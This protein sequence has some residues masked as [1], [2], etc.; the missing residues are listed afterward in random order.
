MD[1]LLALITL[2]ALAYFVAWEDYIKPWLVLD[3]PRRVK[4]LPPLPVYRARSARSARSNA[5][6]AG[7][8]QQG[9]TFGGSNV[10]P[11][12]QG[13]GPSS[14]PAGL[15]DVAPGALAITTNELQQLADALI[16]RAKGATVEEAIHGAFGVRKG[17]GAGYKRAKELFDTA[18]KAP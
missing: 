14:A 5:L 18:T 10:Q 16:L 8:A 1:A 11:N 15:L 12:V 2:A 7:S 6:N 4:S 3:K 17:G 13:S 9:A